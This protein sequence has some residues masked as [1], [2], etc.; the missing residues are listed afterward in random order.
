MTFDSTPIRRNSVSVVETG[1]SLMAIRIKDSG[2]Q[3]TKM[4]VF[5]W[6]RDFVIGVCKGTQLERLRFLRAWLSLALASETSL[7][8]PDAC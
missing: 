6:V 2:G 3:I 7:S 5:M 4:Y 1:I 8:L